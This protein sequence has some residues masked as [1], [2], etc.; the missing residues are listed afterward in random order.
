MRRVVLVCVLTLLI[1]GLAPTATA[2]VVLPPTVGLPAR[3]SLAPG[4][5]YDLALETLAKGD[6]SAALEL[7]ERNASG[8][9]RI[10]ADRWIDSIAAAAVVGECLFELGRYREAVARYEEA[11]N[12]QAAYSPWLLSVQFPQQPLQPVRRP[13]AAGWGRSQRNTL[14]AALPERMTIRQ[15]APDVQETLQKGGVLASDYDRPIRPQEIVRSLA[16]ATYRLGSIMGELGHDNPAL[17]AAARGLAKRPAPPNHYSQ[18]WID[19]P[20]GI[21]LWAQGKPDQAQPLLTRGLVIGNQFDHPLTAW[22]LIVL[23]R[24]ALDADRFDEAVKYFEEATYAAADDGDIRALEEAFELTWTA[25]HLAGLRGVPPT[26]RL[27]ADGTRGGPAVLRARL[28]AMEAE[29]AAAA[30][31]R[32]TAEAAIRQIDGRLLRGDAGR[33][34]LGW[35]TAYASALAEYAVGDV[36]AGDAALGQALSIARGRS[37][38]LFRLGLLV[39]LV[40]SGSNRVSARQADGWF[41]DWLADPSPRAIAAD[42]IGSLALVTAP[43]EAAFD[44][45][46]AAAGSRGNEEALA[47]AEATMRNRWIAAR[48]L[49]G[50]GVSITRFLASDRR[51]LEPAEAARR[52]AFVTGT[53]GLDAILTRSAQLRGDLAADVAAAPADAGLGGEPGTWREYLEVSVR[54]QQVIA[55]AAAGRLAT[56]PA[57]PPLLSATEIRQRLSPR[58]ALLSFHWT[59]SG[60][61]AALE[62]GDRLVAW[63]VKQADGIAGELAVLAKEFG[64]S[65]RATAVGT[66]RLS[67]GAWQGSAARIERML[68]ENSRGVSLATGIDEL[69]IVP[70][71]WLWYFPFELLPIA[72][73]QAGDDV[74][75]LRDLCQI[76]YAPTRSLAVLR[77]EPRENGLTGG[78]VGRMSRGEKPAAALEAMDA[79]LAGVDRRVTIEPLAL[80]VPPALVGSIFDALVIADELPASDVATLPLLSGGAGRPGITA[81][82]W[83]AAPVKRPQQVILPGLQSAFAGGLTKPPPRPGSELFL[84]ATDLIAAGAHTALISRWRMGG[85]TAGDLVREFVQET[86]RGQPAAAAWQ[87]AVDL[88]LPEPPDLAREPRLEQD[89]DAVWSDSRHPL[90]WSGYL[91]IDCGGGSYEPAAADGGMARPAVQPPV[92]PVEPPAPAAGPMPPAILAPPPERAEP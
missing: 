63:Q 5:G 16:I 1:S 10:G 18:A 64:L 91:L 51:V 89:T 40:R 66:N 80:S 44:A 73:N 24:I 67:A 32:Q 56:P 2:Q 43:R 70:D 33:G 59:S 47:A 77:F 57:F 60:L 75:P 11:L 62:T 52:D 86:T 84:T 19:V 30:G 74:R 13:R 58:Q 6:S 55:A 31:D 15:K 79:M 90:L 4:P 27:A 68:F 22:A 78:I 81:A 87:R 85:L 25:H 83:L 65:D 20:L 92:R 61:F 49:G 45:W 3:A 36:I 76:R 53:P 41:A 38:P 26:I 9:V 23:G 34:P 54:F 29:A 72:S 14:P 37:L 17:E 39:D 12:L 48:P 7:A 42:P 82:D 28:L 88:V 71:G 21:A 8:C 46:V 69:V 35:I 50:R